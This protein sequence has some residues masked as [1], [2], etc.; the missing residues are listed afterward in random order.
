MIPAALV[1][2]APQAVAETPPTIPKTISASTKPPAPAFAAHAQ[3]TP[4]QQQTLVPAGPGGTPP[5]GQQRISR[6]AL[7]IG[8]LVA[9]GGV[10][11]GGFSAVH[12]LSSPPSP[13]R[14]ANSIS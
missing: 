3:S 1:P 2:A 7:L 13:N 4:R 8:G 10:V 5:P 11:G 6:R 12:L 14:C 9:A